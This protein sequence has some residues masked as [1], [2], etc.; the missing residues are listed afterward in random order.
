[1][2]SVQKQSVLWWVAGAFYI[3]K[4]RELLLTSSFFVLLVTNKDLSPVLLHWKPWVM[5]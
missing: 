5:L 4:P 3:G 2:S 1:L